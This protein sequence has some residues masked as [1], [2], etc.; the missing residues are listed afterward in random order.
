MSRWRTGSFGSSARAFSHSASAASACPPESRSEPSRKCAVASAGLDLDRA[1]QHGHR[2]GTVREH[3]AGRLPRG[4]GKVLAPGAAGLLGAVATV[5]RDQRVVLRQRHP[6]LR[7]D[8]RRRVAAREQRVRVVPQAERHV[9]HG[10]L[11]DPLGVTRQVGPQRLVGGAEQD[12]LVPQERA[13]RVDGPPAGQSPPRFGRA[14]RAP[15]QGDLHAAGA[16][17]LRRL[18]E[19][20]ANEAQSLFGMA[21]ARCEPA[22]LQQRRGTPAGQRRGLVP[23]EAGRL[24]V[25]EGEAGEAEV[26][27]RLGVVAAPCHRLRERSDGLL[28]ALHL[29]REASRGELE[30]GAVGE[31]GE[32]GRVDV[33]GLQQL[34]VELLMSTELQPVPLTALFRRREHVRRLRTRLHLRL[35]QHVVATLGLRDQ[36]PA[37]RVPHLDRVRAGGRQ[38]CEAA[39]EDAGRRELERQLAHDRGP[40]ADDH[41]A[42]PQGARQVEPHL[43]RAALAA[44]H[45]HD[46]LVVRARVAADP[47]DRLVRLAEAQQLLRLEERVRLLV[48]EEARLD[49][50]VRA[51]VVR[52]RLAPV[53]ALVVPAPGP[54]LLARQVV[55]IRHVDHA[56]LR[57]GVVD[58]HE[59]L[60]AAVHEARDEAAGMVAGVAEVLAEESTGQVSTS[61]KWCAAVNSI[62]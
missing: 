30:L 26:V 31:R 58:A 20:L 28:V 48:A 11:E 61:A 10:Q 3:V 2:L 62:G 59:W 35:R 23:R 6:R 45:V 55:V 46:A 29:H 13:R 8:T 37:L 54:D 57:A 22:E 32:R 16:D 21:F 44:A 7:H 27:E 49:L 15:E 53:L 47:P 18:R 9:V 24:R 17:H 38:V 4:E 41:A 50:E 12:R 42:A 60:A 36:N 39:V 34:P 51:L 5:V 19:R 52:Q 33:V 43:Q 1:A 25:A 40:V 14:P 56:R